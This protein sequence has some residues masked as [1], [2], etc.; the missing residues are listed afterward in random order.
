MALDFERDRTLLYEHPALML[1][2]ISL[3]SRPSERKYYSARLLEI[4]D[5]VLFRMDEAKKSL[6]H[7]N[8]SCA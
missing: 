3:R 6:S 5:E 7:S 1:I 2:A 4:V 8:S